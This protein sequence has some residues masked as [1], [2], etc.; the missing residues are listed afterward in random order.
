MK[1]L[2][3]KITWNDGSQTIMA[4]E[5]KNVLDGHYQIYRELIGQYQKAYWVR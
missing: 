4:V 3:Y 5:A 1:K 2:K